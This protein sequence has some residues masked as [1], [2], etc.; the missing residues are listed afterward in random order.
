MRDWCASLGPMA[1]PA[2]Q[3]HF[4]PDPSTIPD[5]PIRLLLGTDTRLTTTR[6]GQFLCYTLNPPGDAP[7]RPGSVVYVHGG[8]YVSEIHAAHW[9]LV[10]DIATSSNRAVHV[11]IYH[12]EPGAIHIYPL[13]PVP[14]G[15]NART[16]LLAHIANT[17]NP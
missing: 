4:C 1:P 14:E 12:E 9:K 8:G 16:S 2:A 10:A 7:S 5:R 11:P 3:K 13:L 6:Y 15:R 17:L